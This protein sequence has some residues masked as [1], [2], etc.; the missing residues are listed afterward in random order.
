MRPMKIMLVVLFCALIPIKGAIRC[1][2]TPWGRHMIGEINR[3]LLK[4]R[5]LPEYRHIIEEWAVPTGQGAAYWK[6]Y[7]EQVL[8][9]KK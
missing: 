7:E 6:V 3:I 8:N 1:P 4:I 5:P 2:D 9:V